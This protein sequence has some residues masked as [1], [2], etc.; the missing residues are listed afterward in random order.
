[1]VATADVRP[2]LAFGVSMAIA[3]DYDPVDEITAVAMPSSK[4]VP[5]DV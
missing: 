5:T 3:F 2:R 4:R 1:L